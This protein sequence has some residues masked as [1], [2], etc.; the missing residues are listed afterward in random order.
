MVLCL[1]VPKK[2]A[3]RA[4]QLLSERKWLAGEYGVSRMGDE[5]FLPI[6]PS[7]RQEVR[8]L[9]IGSLAELFMP[10]LARKPQSLSE[11][12]DGQLAPDEMEQLI[13]S[14]DI[15]GDIAVLEIPAAL[16]SKRAAIAAA[17]LA[18]HPQVKVVAAKTG[19]TGG[20]FRIRPVEVM[21]GPNRNKVVLNP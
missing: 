10:P 6:L 11:A 21:A 3:E 2:D 18:I 16:Q 20:P 12:L 9:G 1:K 17:V 4:R 7:A 8:A 19:G 14:F 5:V 13:G 15:I